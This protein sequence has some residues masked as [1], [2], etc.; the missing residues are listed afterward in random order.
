L[1]SKLEPA[2]VN[3]RVHKLHT[4]VVL[5]PLDGVHV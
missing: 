5:W 4:Y 1:V 2:L 3:G